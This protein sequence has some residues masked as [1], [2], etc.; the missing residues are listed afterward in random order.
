MKKNIAFWQVDAFTKEAFKGNP[1]AVCLLTET[2]SDEL[3]QNIALEM[4]LSETAF[5]LPRKA[6]HPLLRWFTP[7]YEIDLCGHAT[8]AS[9]SIYLNEIYPNLNEVI[10]DT[11]LA[12]QLTVTKNK[13]DYTMNFPA[14]PGKAIDLSAIPS[15]VITA[16]NSLVKPIAAYQA[17]DMMLVYDNEQVIHDFEPDFMTLKK[18]GK[19]IVTAKSNNK[20][21]DFISRFFC[22][23]I[24]KNEDPVT[25][26]AHCTL[27][28]YWSE[29]LGKTSMLAY[30]ASDRGGE[31][32]I[33]IAENNRINLSGNAI[34][35]M[36][37]EIILPTE[38]T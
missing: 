16:L 14:R 20:P 9:A 8:L 22:S 23:D 18:H 6:Q 32:A 27:A 7:G 24:G 30:Q 19:I 38:Q 12:G 33:E 15:D 10:F 36:K 37:G 17:R 2:I 35:V 29:Q 11:K 31:I 28:P 25:G 4:N 13:D 26:S 5:I 34:T 3:M 1:A 21:Y